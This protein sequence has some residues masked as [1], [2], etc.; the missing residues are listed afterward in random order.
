[1]HNFHFKL[2]CCHLMDLGV[3]AL[4]PNYLHSAGLGATAPKMQSAIS[5]YPYFL[6]SDFLNFGDPND[7]V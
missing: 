5:H 3:Y 1:M 4:T 2:Y 6:P 7:Y